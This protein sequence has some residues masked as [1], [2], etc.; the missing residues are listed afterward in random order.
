MA[1]FALGMLVLAP[2]AVAETAKGWLLYTDLQSYWGT[3]EIAGVLRRG[4][5]VRAQATSG[6]PIVLGF[7]MAI[8]I[9]FWLYLR[10]HVASIKWRALAMLTLAAG[11]IAPFAR[12]PWLGA[13]TIVIVFLALG[14]NRAGRIVKTVVPLAVV[15][16]LVLASPY[17]DQIVDRLPFIGTLDAGAISYRED[18]AA[19]SWQIIKQNPWFGTPGFIT[20]METLRQG[21]GIIDLVNAYAGLGL[22]NGLVDVAFFF[23]LFMLIAVRCLR[24]IRSVRF[25]DPGL[26]LMGASLVASIAGALL[27]LAT[28][29]LYLSVSYLTWALSGLALGYAGLVRRQHESTMADL[30]TRPASSLGDRAVARVEAAGTK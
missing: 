9:G 26:S 28:V 24:D 2:V 16:L 19:T 7:A 13:V 5:T 25:S 20:Q 21:Q 1:A 29:N 22:A 27:M 14:P 6:Q 8:A 15:G 17:G 3:P 23:G 12:G 10:T 4:G 11:L 30:G 18:L